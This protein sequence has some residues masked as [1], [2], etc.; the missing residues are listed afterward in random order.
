[1]ATYLD[2]DGEYENDEEKTLNRDP[3]GRDDYYYSEEEDRYVPDPK[4][5]HDNEEDN[6]EKWW[7]QFND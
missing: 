1:M 7:D 2:I 5:H 3:E 6:P 4:Y